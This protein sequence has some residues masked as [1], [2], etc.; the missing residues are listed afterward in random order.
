MTLGKTILQDTL[1]DSIC[2]SLTYFF[3]HFLQITL[4]EVHT[5]SQPMGLILPA[6][7]Q[8]QEHIQPEQLNLECDDVPPEDEE[9]SRSELEENEDILSQDYRYYLDDWCVSG[10]EGTDSYVF[11]KDVNNMTVD[12]VKRYNTLHELAITMSPFVAHIGT[13][14][15]YTRGT[16][17]EHQKKKGR[18]EDRKHIVTQAALEVGTNVMESDDPGIISAIVPSQKQLYELSLQANQHDPFVQPVGSGEVE[19]TARYT[20]TYR[21]CCVYPLSYHVFTRLVHFV[22]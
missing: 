15:R 16:P 20:F 22:L 14:H 19:Q 11:S 10:E 21:M 3:T 17:E 1:H 8:D 7:T 2:D 13:C 18:T 12:W 6:Q 5:S 4:H 9:D